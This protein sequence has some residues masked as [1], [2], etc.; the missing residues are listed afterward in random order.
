M[1]HKISVIVCAVM[2]INLTADA[3]AQAGGATVETADASAQADGAK[4]ET[5][6]ESAQAGGATVGTVDESAQ[7]GGDVYA[8]YAE[9]HSV[10]IK[11]DTI[12]NSKTECCLTGTGKMKLDRRRVCSLPV[13]SN[14]CGKECTSWH[15][16]ENG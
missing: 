6:N 16:R 4:V 9:M 7:A 14:Y 8:K 3:S 1:T 15:S 10:S 11:M 12:G 5:A 13:C 2:T